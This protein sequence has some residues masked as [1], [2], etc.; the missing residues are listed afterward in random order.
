MPYIQFFVEGI[1]KA[2]PRPR[3]AHHKGHTRVFDPGTAEGWKGRIAMEAVGYR[4]ESPHL[5]AVSIELTFRMPR[6][7]SHFGTGKNNGKLKDSSP[8]KHLSKPD[9]DN[10]EKAVLDEL[11]MLGFWRDDSQI[12][13]MAS[14]KRYTKGKSGVD[15][16]IDMLDS[17]DG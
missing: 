17:G 9:I 11:T 12:T 15:I 16:S 2:Q 14:R 10:L 3:A 4:P 13:D 6:P 8:F 1:P 5:G 7:K